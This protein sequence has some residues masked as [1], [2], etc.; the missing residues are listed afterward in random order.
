VDL[1]GER[2]RL[3]RTRPEDADVEAPI[4]ALPDVARFTGRNL[5][6]PQSAARLREAGADLT[7]R[8]VW[9]VVSREDGS[10]LGDTTLFRFNYTDRHCWFAITLG[11]PERLGRGLG[12]ETTILVTR[13]AFR[14]LGMEK[15]CLAVFEGNERGIRAYRKAGYEVEATLRRHHL[16]EGQ[17]VDEH[18]MAAFRDHPLYG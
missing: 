15:V 12:T 1:I 16:L 13:F 9:T 5:L 14:Q 11:P 3:R 18:W 4:F 7:G 17:L 10:V 8:L 2:V 6:L